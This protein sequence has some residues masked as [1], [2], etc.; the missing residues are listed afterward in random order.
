LKRDLGYSEIFQ[1]LKAFWIVIMLA[2]LW[3]RTRECVYAAWTLLYAYLLCDD[4]FQ[5]HER[6]GGAIARYRDYEGAFRQTA[7]DFGELT[8]FG[9]SGLFS[10]VLISITYLRST[11]EARNASKDLILLFGLIAFFGIV[12]D[13]VHSLAAEGGYLEAVLGVV[14]DGGEM[15]AMSVVC[16]YVMNLLEH[17]GNVPVSLRQ[18]TKMAAVARSWFA[19]SSTKVY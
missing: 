16:W 7:Q 18:R 15:F 14:E 3:W 4:A 10:L 19:S 2:A 17:R 13:V 5:I 6:V 1:Y 9:V 12:V 8:V 11:R